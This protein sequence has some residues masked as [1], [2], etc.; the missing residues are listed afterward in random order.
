[1]L[2]WAAIEE[3]TIRSAATRSKRREVIFMGGGYNKN[4][5]G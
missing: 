2:D 3:A 4:G 5:A 1:V